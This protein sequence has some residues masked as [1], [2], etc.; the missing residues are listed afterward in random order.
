MKKITNKE[1]AQSPDW[2]YS[3]EKGYIFVGTINPHRDYIN[4]LE[5]KENKFPKKKSRSKGGK[6][7]QG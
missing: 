6:K 4:I 3:A 5:N 1:M 2:T 7:W